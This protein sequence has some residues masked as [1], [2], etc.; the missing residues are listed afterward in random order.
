MSATHD[1]RDR[2]EAREHGGLR[3]AEIRSVSF[4]VT[5]GSRYGILENE[6]YRWPI[7]S[8]GT[9]SVQM[10]KLSG[11]LLRIELSGAALDDRELAFV[12]DC[13][14]P[15]LAPNGRLGVLVDLSWQ[16]RGVRLSVQNELLAEHLFA[17]H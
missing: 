10:S 1:F 14:P 15:E 12:M 13:P 11:D 17:L 9:M 8:F 4:W 7:L 5:G 16:P 6:E 3:G 2:D